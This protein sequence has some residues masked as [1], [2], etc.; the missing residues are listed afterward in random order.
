MIILSL[1]ETLEFG[2]SEQW[3]VANSKPNPSGY[4]KLSKGPGVPANGVSL[5]ST[6]R[7]R[8]VD[9]SYHPGS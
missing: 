5:R 9:Q 4:G 6:P 7:H 2:R 8:G 1:G 3:N